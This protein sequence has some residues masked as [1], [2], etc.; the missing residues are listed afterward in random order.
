MNLL[1]FLFSIIL[2]IVS[3]THLDGQVTIWSVD[4]ETGYSDNDVSAQDNNLPAG[5]DWTKSGTPSNWWR[6]ES[7]NVLSDN[8]SMSGRNTDGIMSWTSESINITGFTDVSISINI[9]EINCENTD[10]IETFYNT[11]SGAIEF[12]NGNGNGDFNSATNTITGLSGTSLVITVSLNNDGGGERLIFDDILVTGT[13][14]PSQGYLGPGGVGDTDGTGEMTFWL[15]ANQGVSSTGGRLT[16]WDDQSGYNNNATPPGVS[17]RPIFTTAGINSQNLID[18]DGTDYLTALDDNSLDFT[19]WSIFVVTRINAHK[20]YNAFVVKGADATENYEFLTNFP[21]TGNI[22]Y[23]VYY[24]DASRSS[25][26]EPGET[27]ST[28]DFGI[29]QLDY[30][31]SNLQIYINGLLTETDPETRTP[32]TNSNSLYI[33]NEEGTTG[34]NANAQIAEIIMYS[35]PLNE[36]ERLIVHNA[37]SAKYGFTLDANDL[38]NEDET[39]AGDY[40]FDVAGIGQS[41]LAEN[42]QDA[43]GTGIVR[44]QNPSDLDNSEYLFWG[45]DNEALNAFGVSDLP[46]GVERRFART[47]RVSETGDVGTVTFSIDL[48]TVF[49]GKVAADLRLLIDSDNDGIFADE[50]GSAVIS[51]AV[52]TSGD[53]FEWTGVDLENNRRF[54]IGSV[55]ESTTP[56]PIELVEFKGKKIYPSIIE[57]SWKTRSELN[58]AWFEVQ[59]MTSPNQWNTIAQINGAGNSSIELAYSSLDK[60]PNLGMNYYQ[61]KQIDFDGKFSFSN[62]IGVLNSEESIEINQIYPNPS[63]GI[64]H[65]ELDNNLTDFKIY[66]LRSKDLTEQVQIDKESKNIHLQSLPDGVY[67]IQLNKKTHRLLLLK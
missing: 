30:D 31:Q 47:W 2:I 20:N 54:T 33:A 36:A 4:F 24:T 6:V 45:H 37:M 17:N 42:H 15:D 18:F 44:I 57:L 39:S 56:L 66:D 1:K 62:I 38:Y 41:S 16:Q 7:D 11:G 51:G 23:P 19:T 25:D 26:A 21:S 49:G 12:G 27:V 61:L 65:Y 64:L 14:N 53:I 9:K 28:A 67:F 55:Q 35:S 13:A 63:N 50:T 60:S 43:Q 59:K 5:A 46:A 52:N 10:I 3:T 48:S 29:Y 58:N 40:D 32:Q 8:F 34:R 22:H